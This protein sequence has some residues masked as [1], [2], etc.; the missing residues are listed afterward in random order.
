VITGGA[1]FIRSNLADRVLADGVQVAV[2]ENS[3]AGRHEFL[4]DGLGHLD[5]TVDWLEANG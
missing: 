4:A 3:S 2:Y 5:W 1:G